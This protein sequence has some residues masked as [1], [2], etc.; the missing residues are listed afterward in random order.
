MTFE[1]N[2][3]NLNTDKY[4]FGCL[5]LGA[6]DAVLAVIPLPKIILSA[7]VG[8]VLTIKFAIKGRKPGEIIFLNRDFPSRAEWDVFKK[9][10]NSDF[11]DKMAQFERNKTSI[12]NAFDAK[13]A[14][15]QAMKEK[16]E[17]DLQVYR[18]DL[19]TQIAQNRQEVLDTLAPDSVQTEVQTRVENKVF[20]VLDAR[21]N[22]LFT[23]KQA[24]LE[25]AL[26][27][28][29]S[30]LDAFKN[31]V[32]TQIQG[33][34]GDLSRALEELKRVFAEKG[35]KGQT[36]R[37]YNAYKNGRNSTWCNAPAHSFI[38]ALFRYQQ[39]TFV[40]GTSYPGIAH[41]VYSNFTQCFVNSSS[42]E[43]AIEL[44]SAPSLDSNNTYPAYACYAIT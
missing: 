14:A 15:L 34:I 17:S 21:I 10:F 16:F 35:V 44:V 27:D 23:P 31:Q 11:L 36:L 33:K 30:G 24:K 13:I 1:I 2:L 12:L 8:G 39:G 38:I 26:A 32:D 7:E 41:Y 43:R 19:S 28:Y 5:I 20:E 25:Q 42:E 22:T 4:L 9:T 6:D 40:Y 18:H 37:I 29:K 3:G